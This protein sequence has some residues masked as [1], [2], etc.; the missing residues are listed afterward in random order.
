[1]HEKLPEIWESQ[2]MLNYSWRVLSRAGLPL[3]DISSGVLD[4]IWVGELVDMQLMLGEL[5]AINN[6]V[7]FECDHCDHV[8]M[9]LRVKSREG[10]SAKYGPRTKKYV[11][12]Q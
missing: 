3:S 8:A 2:K 4:C 9:Y 7:R 11:N 10:V 12:L 1:M 6:G 5:L